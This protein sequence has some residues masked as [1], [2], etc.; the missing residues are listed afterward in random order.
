MHEI[1]RNLTQITYGLIYAIKFISVN[2]LHS[3]RFGECVLS[4]NFA[5]IF[6][7]MLNSIRNLLPWSPI[8]QNEPELK[9]LIENVT[10]ILLPASN[11]QQE[12]KLITLAAAHFL[13]TVSSYRPRYML[14]CASFKQLI[15]MGNQLNYLDGQAAKFI[16]NA[17]V[18]CYVLP[19]P[20]LSNAD[21]EN[22][23][24]KLQDYVQNLSENLLILD[25]TVM[26]N[27]QDKV[28]KVVTVVL[29]T[30]NDIIDNHR[31]SSSSCKQM[32]V[33]AY[34]P[35]IT[36]SILIYK[37]FGAHNEDI[38]SCILKF[39]LSVIRTLQIQLTSPYISDMLDIFLKT[40]TRYLMIFSSNN[41]L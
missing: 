15:Q 37:E 5:E 25:H 36:K 32:L 21:H 1:P 6:A 11:L 23:Q 38:A 22:R 35:S 34:R 26:H 20:H 28:I 41:L 13:L 30:L 27:Q 12:P 24:V 18:N 19:W 40:T 3:V 31:E 29:P 14:D 17:I 7:Q 8:L 9:S 2:K 16:Q 33:N 4:S 39:V 10:Q